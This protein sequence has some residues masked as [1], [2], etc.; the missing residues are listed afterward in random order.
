M[1]NQRGLIPSSFFPSLHAIAVGESKEDRRIRRREWHQVPLNPSKPER[2]LTQVFD[3][4]RL[5]LLPG[6][7]IVL[8]K[9]TSTR[10]T[11]RCSHEHGQLRYTASFL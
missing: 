1:N 11:I 10:I 4:V 3:D 7:F 6:L 9:L 8:L 2:L 5:L